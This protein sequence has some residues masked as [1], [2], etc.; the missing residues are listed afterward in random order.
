M[1]HSEPV[2]DERAVIADEFERRGLELTDEDRAA[3]EEQFASQL[4]PPPADGSAPDPAAGQEVFDSFSEEFQD[5]EVTFNAR[6]AVLSDAFAAEAQQDA[7]V[8]DADVQ[9]YYDDN[10][11]Q[12]TQNCASHILVDT[13][14]EADNLRQQIDGGADFAALA[15]KHS[16]CPSGKRGGDLGFFG[17]GRMVKPFEE[18]AFG[19]AKGTCSDPVQTQFGYHLIMVT[20]SK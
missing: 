19:L 9:A 2:G 1:H 6:A 10:Q 3:A 11:D 12:F 8:T 16:N 14:E 4:A 7:D 20:D 15:S 5:F 18:A 13:K 17:K